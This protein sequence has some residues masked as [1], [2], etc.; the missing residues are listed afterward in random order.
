[1]RS[2]HTIRGFIHGQIHTFLM[3]GMSLDFGSHTLQSPLLLS[4]ASA[5]PPHNMPESC[6]YQEGPSHAIQLAD[7]PL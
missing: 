3:R 2:I 1:M 6:S 4:S 7:R 5:S